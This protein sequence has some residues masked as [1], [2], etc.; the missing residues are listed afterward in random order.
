M[1]RGDYNSPFPYGYPATGVC[2]FCRQ[3]ALHTDML[4]YGTRHWAHWVCFFKRKGFGEMI[5]LQAWQLRHMPVLLT[6]EAGLTKAQYDEV[7]RK[8]KEDDALLRR[9]RKARG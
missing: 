2:R 8:I 5:A 9:E 4:K 1:P 3:W 6:M 7:C